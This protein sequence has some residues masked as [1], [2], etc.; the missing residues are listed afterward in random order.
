MRIT[1]CDWVD[2]GITTGESGVFASELRVIGFVYVCV[3][4]GGIS[5]QVVPALAPRY[6]VPL[7][8]AVKKA[9]GI[10]VQPGRH[11][12]QPAAGGRDHY[13]LNTSNLKT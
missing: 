13:A 11:D 12:C 3:S 4:S 6:Q 8:A 5:P 2:G 1:S 7:A 10:A 9:S